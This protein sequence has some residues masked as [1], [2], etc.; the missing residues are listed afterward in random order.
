[1]LSYLRVLVPSL[2]LFS[3]RSRPRRVS[4]IYLSIGIILPIMYSYEM[5]GEFDFKGKFRSAIL[6]NLIFYLVALVV[7]LFMLLYY[8][9]YGNLTM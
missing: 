4:H 6:E 8:V 5:A 9:A 3:T 2:T 7:L 1:M